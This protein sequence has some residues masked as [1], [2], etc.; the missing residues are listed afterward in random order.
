[1]IQCKIISRLAYWRIA[2][3]A[4]P[5]IIL[6][7][8]RRLIAQKFDGTKRRL[9]PGRRRID[10]ETERLIVRMARKNIGWD[11]TGSSVL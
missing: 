4:K 3:L 11:T 9:H 10:G 2:C 8:Y 7:W 1:M 6:A 5:D